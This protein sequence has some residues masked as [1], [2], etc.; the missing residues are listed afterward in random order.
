MYTLHY[1]A[2]GHGGGY[3]IAFGPSAT[4][5]GLRGQTADNRQPTNQKTSKARGQQTNR[6]TDEQSNKL[7]TRQTPRSEI[8]PKSTKNIQNINQNSSKMCLGGCLGR[9]LGLFGAS[10]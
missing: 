8:H 9:F 5:P 10:A 3:P 4:V 1:R 2:W 7:S 6:P